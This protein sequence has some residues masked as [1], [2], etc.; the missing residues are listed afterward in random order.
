M[1]KSLLAYLYRFLSF[2]SPSDLCLKLI[3]KW[4]NDKLQTAHD[5]RREGIMIA[6]TQDCLDGLRKC[7]HQLILFSSKPSLTTHVLMTR[8]AQVYDLNELY[9][10]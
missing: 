1:T 4:S 2:I 8:K 5:K 6:P 10:P 7:Q 3:S 9:T